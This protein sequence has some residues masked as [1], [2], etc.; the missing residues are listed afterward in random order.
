MHDWQIS[1]IEELG[2]NGKENIENRFFEA[3]G[4]CRF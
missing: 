1:A 3:N 4:Y 2:E